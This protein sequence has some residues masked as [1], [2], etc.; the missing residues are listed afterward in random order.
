MSAPT[1]RGRRNDTYQQWLALATNRSKRH[2][3]RSFLIQGV[4]PLD[5]AVGRGWPLRALLHGDRPRS[6]WAEELLAGPTAAQRVQLSR[7]LLTELGG[8]DDGVA[9]IVG[10]AVIPDDDLARL[11]PAPTL[12]VAADRP[13]SPGNLGSLI[14]S[15]DALG[16]DGLIITGH[17]VDPYDP[18]VV[19]ASRGSLF[20][21]PTVRAAAAGDVMRWAAERPRALQVL[22]ASDEA[23]T[24][25]WDHDFS[26]PTLVVVGNEAAGM[27]RG[28]SEACVATVRIPMVGSASSLNAAIAGS[29]VLYEAARQRSP[30]G[31]GS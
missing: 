23:T 21:L 19:R 27:S 31:H 13:S 6:R 28:W 18:R 24:D 10:V 7:E 12:V 3:D 9:E 8:K 14:R 15:A 25:V 11:G 4:R 20:A 1:T 17:A 22:G 5:L 16:A 2:R 29:I 26:S 30:G